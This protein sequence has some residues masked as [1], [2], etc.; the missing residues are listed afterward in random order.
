MP[1]VYDYDDE[2][3]DLSIDADSPD[4]NFYILDGLTDF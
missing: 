4:D 1:E 2:T 3:G